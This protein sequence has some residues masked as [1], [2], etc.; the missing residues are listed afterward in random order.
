MLSPR[1]RCS[2][3]TRPRPDHLGPEMR[4]DR[5][6]DGSVAWP[7]S[8]ARRPLRRRARAVRGDAQAEA[9]DRIWA[10]TSTRTPGAAGGG[11]GWAA[12]EGAEAGG[13]PHG[14]SGELRNRPRG[15]QGVGQDPAA[16]VLHG[17]TAHACAALQAARRAASGGVR[18]E[19]LRRYTRPRGHRRP[20][21]FWRLRTSSHQ[22]P[23]QRLTGSPGATQS[24]RSHWHEGALRADVSQAGPRRAAPLRESSPW[25][26]ARQA[27]S[28]VLRA[29]ASRRR[30]CRR[31]IAKTSGAK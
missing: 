1:R 31:K 12:A 16:A 18:G 22:G 19:P 17:V 15:S 7:V 13:L 2:R 23:R 11:H 29:H 24:T 30:V 5:R 9:G 25:W 28:G 27:H 10:A 21:P 26:A 4:F 3:S 14:D 8:E 6:G 20:P